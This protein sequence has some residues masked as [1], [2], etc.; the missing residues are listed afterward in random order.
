[1]IKGIS[2]KVAQL[3]LEGWSSRG[4]CRGVSGHVSLKF[5]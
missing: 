1:V 2:D 4:Q 5:V 3:R